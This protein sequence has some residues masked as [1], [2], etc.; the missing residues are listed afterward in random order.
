V[1]C[2]L[3]R[4]VP[5]VLIPLALA[6]CLG[7]SAQYPQST[8]HPKSDFTRLLDGVL[9][10][11]VWAAIVVFILVEGALVWVVFRYRGKPNDPEPKQVHG[12]TTL[13]IIWTAI[14]ALLLA[15]I[16]V[17][18]VKAI[19]QT[20]EIPKDALTVDVIGHQWW[21]EFRYP[22]YGVVTANELH[23]PAGKM[24]LLKMK[25]ADVLHSFWSP[26]FAAKRDVF[27]NR[28]TTL[29]FTA[30]TTGYFSGQC[31]EFCGT[32][33]GRMAFEI[34]STS[35]EEFD[36]YIKGLQATAVKPATDSAGTTP[37]S[38]DTTRV[39]TLAAA[40]AALDPA[41]QA[42]IDSGA[43]L[44]RSCSACHSLDA[45]STAN[46]IGP[47]LANIGS[48]R[49]IGARTLPNTDANL[50][51]WIYDPQVIKH[52]ILMPKLGLTHEQATMVAQYLR[53]HR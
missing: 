34:K 17:P 27:P 43:K 39:S 32:Q 41:T 14:P 8:L 18:T 31:A 29:W 44:F 15:I 53:T 19:F 45:T 9:M 4:W 48:R 20:Y 7:T 37:A 6:A 24:V 16:A 35:P 1:A 46:L 40:T 25:T 33:H 47:N 49:Y 36:S 50:A 51:K 38:P 12:N 26:E 42:A 28:L 5:A 23:V 13:E 10:N 22:D 11:T 30:D 21:W 52:G 2:R 3:R